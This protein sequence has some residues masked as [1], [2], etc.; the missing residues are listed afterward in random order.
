MDYQE[1]Y[2]ELDNIIS[3]ISVL[4]D[5]I[6]DMYYKDMLNEIKYEAKSELDEIRTKMLE[7]NKKENFKRNQD[8]ERSRL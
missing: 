3:S 6:S 4:T 5:E 8:F 2:D 7:E 1:K